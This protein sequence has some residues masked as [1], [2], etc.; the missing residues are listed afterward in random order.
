MI[1]TPGHSDDL[2]CT[3]LT[4]ETPFGK[5]TIELVHDS[6]RYSDNGKYRVGV[7]I[8]DDMD[9]DFW[10]TD[11]S[12]EPALFNSVAEAQECVL[13]CLHNYIQELRGETEK[14]ISDIQ[15]YLDVMEGRKPPQA[16]KK[17]AKKAPVKKKP[18]KK[19]KK[20]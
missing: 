20:R 16:A 1:W 19:T 7:S 5:F 3:W 17:P 11:E 15:E 2:S 12:D 9:E 4:T 10:V 18:A 13:P 6:E 14:E 8:S